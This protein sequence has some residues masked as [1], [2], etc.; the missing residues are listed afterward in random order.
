MNTNITGFRW[1]S[2]MFASCAS[3]DESNLSIG[4]VSNQTIHMSITYE[5]FH[6]NITP[7]QAY[8]VN[9]VV[10]VFKY[11]VVSLEK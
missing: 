9:R 5:Y 2:K 8:R 7:M 3:L 1:F 11:I 10:F 4:R 6:L